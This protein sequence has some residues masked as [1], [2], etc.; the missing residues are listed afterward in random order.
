VTLAAGATVTGQK[1][2]AVTLGLLTLVYGLSLVPA[3]FLASSAASSGHCEA[4]CQSFGR[5]LLMNFYLSY[6]FAAGAAPLAAWI[7]YVFERRQLAW[8]LGLLPLL[9]VP[10][11]GVLAFYLWWFEV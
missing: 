8:I 10:T 9:W 3:L 4:S 7:A 2:Q 6:L 5:L 1:T 11:Y